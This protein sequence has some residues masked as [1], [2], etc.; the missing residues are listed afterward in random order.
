[1]KSQTSN[2]PRMKRRRSAITTL[3]PTRSDLKPVDERPCYA[4]CA[5]LALLLGL[6]AAQGSAQTLTQTPTLMP[7]P[8]PTATPPDLGSIVKVKDVYN[9]RSHSYH[10]PKLWAE[11]GKG[12]IAADHDN[13]DT[14]KAGLNERIVIAVVNLQALLKRSNCEAPYDEKYQKPCIKQPIVLFLDGRVVKGLKPEIIETIPIPTSPNTQSPD[15][16]D[17]AQSSKQFGDGFLS[18]HLRRAADST[19]ERK[20]NLENWADL[21][22]LALSDMDAIHEVK[23]GVG[24]ADGSPIIVE[25]ESKTRLSLVRFSKFWMAVFITFFLLCLLA[26]IWLAWKKELLCDRAPV[27]WGQ[28]MPFSLGSVQAAWWFVI[29]LGSFIFIWLVTGQYDYS[30]TAIILLSISLGTA[31]GGSIIDINK[32]GAPADSNLNGN[33]LDLLL[34]EKRRLEKGLNDLWRSKAKFEEKQA[35]SDE[36]MKDYNKLIGDLTQ[37]FPSAI[38]HH[39]EG[40]IIDI[41]SDA[42]GVSFHRFQMAIWTLVLGGFFI[43]SV[44]SHLEMPEFNTTLLALMGISATAYLGF[45]IPEDTRAPAHTPPTPQPDQAPQLPPPSGA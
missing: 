19:E 38:G 29:I 14:R 5:M 43:I 7:T 36:M 16:M 3:M 21:L 26:L 23:V 13:E 34:A 44:L 31:L 6:A 37:K 17:G 24:L 4:L 42:N 45:K 1:M 25:G 9:F 11:E 41:L 8:T 20:D 12:L 22:G 35:R 39:R 2:A 33:D 15:G 18:F 32:Q 40:F 30:A 28:R 10:D 27:L